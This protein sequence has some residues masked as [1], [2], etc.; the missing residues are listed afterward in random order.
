MSHMFKVLLN[1]ERREKRGW[2]GGLKEENEEHWRGCSI[3]AFR[4]VRRP[5]RRG[6]FRAGT[7]ERNVNL[8]GGEEVLVGPGLLPG[9]F[10]AGQISNTALATSLALNPHFCHRPAS[11]GPRSRPP[12]P[13]TH[14]HCTKTPHPP[15]PGLHCSKQLSE[16][17]RR[18]YI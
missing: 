1:E 17:K 5:K 18:R 2:R 7:E 9:P 6:D 13:N 10:E 14:H 15:S 16:Y 12:P 4:H 11:A 8:R 3:V